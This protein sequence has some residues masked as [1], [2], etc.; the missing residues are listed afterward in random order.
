MSLN[1]EAHGAFYGARNH[2]P[3]EGEHPLMN[4]LRSTQLEKVLDAGTVSSQV[5]LRRTMGETDARR[6][7]FAG[8][9]VDGR[10]EPAYVLG[11]QVRQAKEKGHMEQGTPVVKKAPGKR[12]RPK[13]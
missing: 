13:G 9:L 10:Y 12:F 3:A 7:G 1:G 4:A 2:A 5:R 6:G 11:Y 8:H